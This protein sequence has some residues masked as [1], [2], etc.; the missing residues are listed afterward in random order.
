[1]T[2][3]PSSASAQGDDEGVVV[4]GTLLSSGTSSSYA[5]IIGLPLTTIGVGV[6]VALALIKKES[7]AEL[8]RY[9]NH[10][11]EGV[12]AALH[13]AEPQSGG[14]L[15]DLA[16]LF[17]VSAAHQDRFAALLFERREAL[18]VLLVR[19]RI[20]AEQ[21]FVFASLIVEAMSQDERLDQDLQRQLEAYALELPHPAA[22]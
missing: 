5:T 18:G 21:A 10:N 14:A 17:G 2:A 1:M 15:S 4:G 6:T 16:Q 12:L 19:E 9:L 11:R 22:D 7:S 3:L 13:G 8:K 20:S